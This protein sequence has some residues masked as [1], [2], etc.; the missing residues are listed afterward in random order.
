V[1]QPFI[2]LRIER[3]IYIYIYVYVGLTGAK[4]L[5]RYP[6][7]LQP[8][9]DSKE[10]TSPS[11]C[12]LSLRNKPLH[13]WSTILPALF[14]S[15]TKWIFTVPCLAST[16]IQKWYFSTILVFLNEC[17]SESCS[18]PA[19][20]SRRV[21]VII[22]FSGLEEARYERAVNRLPF[23]AKLIADMW[24][25]ELRYS[26]FWNSAVDVMKKVGSESNSSFFACVDD[27][28]SLQMVSTLLYAQGLDMWSQ[29][30]RYSVLRNS[31]V[32]VMKKIGSESKGFVLCLF[33]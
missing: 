8:H 22:N 1:G 28:S 10:R 13:T 25:H 29:V 33:G 23:L 7:H 6:Y 21:L 3:I 2:S 5:L 11:V 12:S 30:V 14:S 27:V 20:Y 15:E 16:F 32:D 24:S 17:V 18:N 4:G 31:A 9:T 26:V 19:F